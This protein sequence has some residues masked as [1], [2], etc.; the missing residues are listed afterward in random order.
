MCTLEGRTLS[1]QSL[2]QLNCSLLKHLRTLLGMKWPYEDIKYILKII[3]EIEFYN[4]TKIGFIYDPPASASQ[5][6]R[7]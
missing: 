4:V 1:F 5:E 7:L 6:G 2:N 3:S